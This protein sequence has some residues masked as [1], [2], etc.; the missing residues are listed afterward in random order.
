[1][2]DS[3]SIIDFNK[4][5]DMLL[6]Q[7][8]GLREWFFLPT[9]HKNTNTSTLFKPFLEKYKHIDNER[10][11]SKQF[12]FKF[13]SSVKYIGKIIFFYIGMSLFFLAV[14]L[15]PRNKMKG[16]NKV[17][18]E[19][20]EDG[21]NM[22]IGY[23]NYPALINQDRVSLKPKISFLVNLLNIFSLRQILN[24]RLKTKKTKFHIL[25][26]EREMKFSD[27]FEFHCNINLLKSNLPSKLIFNDLNFKDLITNSLNKNM[28]S[29]S[30]FFGFLRKKYFDKHK[31]YFSETKLLLWNENHVYD[32][33][34]CIAMNSEIS[35]VY[36]MQSFAPSYFKNCDTP[37]DID[38]ENSL[39]P[40]KIY[41]VFNTKQSN[42]IIYKKMPAFRLKEYFSSERKF[43]KENFVFFA[44]PLLN[45]DDE[46]YTDLALLA[47]DLKEAGF[48]ISVKFHPL[49]DES[50]KKLF[51]S[52]TNEIN[53]VSSL[54]THLKHAKIVISTGLS[55]VYYESFFFGTVSVNFS[56]PSF[57]I[58]VDLPEGAFFQTTSFKTIL[59]IIDKKRD[60]HE[61]TIEEYLSQFINPSDENIKDFLNEVVNSGQ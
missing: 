36:G 12:N 21:G 2:K 29:R 60:I 18:F 28:V 41:R 14:K 13:F 46:R 10:Y 7:N 59:S 25:F 43:K 17:Y 6:K 61:K 4:L 22:P 33:A 20:F 38:V 31:K 35:N 44:L 45:P 53:I 23:H 39:C 8:K 24:I 11:C 40:K 47:K 58:D 56:N 50:H 52:F 32:R 54:T 26:P 48:N 42:K 1:M 55:T 3:D 15:L 49:Q 27:I 9:F 51:L 30:A 16:G 19:V 37:S 57:K 34:C 5:L